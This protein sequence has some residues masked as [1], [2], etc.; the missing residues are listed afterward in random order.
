VNVNPQAD[1]SL[2]K[3]VSNPNPTVDDEVDHTLTASNAGPNDA[4]GVKITDQL[5]AGLDFID[6]SPGCDNQNGTVT[7][8]V[9]T[10][11][12]GG[13]ASVTIRAHTTAAI[14]GTVVGNLATVSGNEPDPNPNNNQASASI[15]V[16]P[17]VDLKLTKIASNPTPAAGGPVTYTLTLAN[18]G[19]SPATGTTITD[20]LPAGLSFVSANAG[21]GSCSAAAQAVTCQLGTLAAEA[22]RSSRS[23]PR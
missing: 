14:A 22:R 15:A 23:R 7:C 8:D 20:P 4:T 19:P 1:L 2:A 9:G 12:S 5:T 3:T 11:A 10:I 16:Q 13:S 17:L 6:A 18:H 21:Q